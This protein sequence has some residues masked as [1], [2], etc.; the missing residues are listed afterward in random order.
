MCDHIEPVIG[1]YKEDHRMGD[2]FPAHRQGDAAN[3]VLAAQGYNFRRFIQW[4]RLLLRI[5]QALAEAPAPLPA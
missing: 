5:L 4:L 1:H 2:N 3:A